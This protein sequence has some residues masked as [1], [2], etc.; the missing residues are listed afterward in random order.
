MNQFD[1][2]K[3]VLTNGQPNPYANFVRGSINPREQRTVKETVF[4]YASNG[5]LTT[6]LRSTVNR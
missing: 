5:S 3:R 2:N 1:I 4:H 6:K